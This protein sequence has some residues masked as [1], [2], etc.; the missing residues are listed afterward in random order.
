MSYRLPDVLTPTDFSITEMSAL[1]LN[2]EVYRVGDCVSPIDVIPSP[3]QRAA[4]LQAVLP[5][6]LIV[7]RLTA[8]WV[9]G[10]LFSFPPRYELCADAGAR[11]RPLDVERLDIREVVITTADTTDFSGLR[12]TTP[13]RTALDIAR[14]RDDFDE[15]HIEIIARLM[16]MGG[17]ATRQC[18]A[19]L[20]KRKNLPNKLVAL[21]RLVRASAAVAALP[22]GSFH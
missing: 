10:A 1:V 3:Q 22:A 9:W 15:S 7:E 2:G 19:E 12:V 21:E 20:N 11:T 5:P 13:L 16:R 18:A 14:S 4:A 8:G 17:F 6:N